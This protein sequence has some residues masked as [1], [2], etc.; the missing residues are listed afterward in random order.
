MQPGMATPVRPGFV[1]T[2]QIVTLPGD[3]ERALHTSE[4]VHLASLRADGSE[5]TCHAQLWFAWQGG[6]VLVNT[7]ADSWRATNIARGRSR[8]RIWAGNLRGPSANAR[9]TI[10][11]D[12]AT[13]ERLLEAYSAKYPNEI[14]L[15]RD[16]IRNECREGSRVV[17]RYEIG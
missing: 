8:A 6:A 11:D 12:P 4:F 2:S 1:P 13:L 3:L 10:D 7:A 9:G 17:I 16:R 15:W 14:Q 5:G